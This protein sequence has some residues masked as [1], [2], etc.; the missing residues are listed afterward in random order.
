MKQY[1]TYVGL[2]THKKE[3]TV[4]ILYPGED[5]VQ[6]LSV[7]NSPRELQRFVKR[8]KKQAPGEIRMC[9]EAGPCGFE[10]KRQLE[11]EGVTCEVIA[12]SL[13]PFKPG[14]RVKTDRRDARKLAEYYQKGLLTPVHPPTREEEAVRDLCRC[15]EAAKDAQTR[16]RHQLI[17]FLLRHGRSYTEGSYWTHKH[18][19]WLRKQKFAEAVAQ[20]TY[21]DY[22][23]EVERCSERVKTLEQELDRIAQQ[24]PYRTPVGWLRCFRG[25]DTVTAITIVSELYGFQR[26]T[27]PRQL[28]AFLGLTPS[29]DSTGER[30]KQGAI[31]KAGNQHVRRLLIEASWH[32][33]HPVRVGRGLKKRR[34]GQPKWVIQIADKA[35]R[36]LH[37]RYA[38]L[39]RQGKKETVAIAAVAREMVGFLWSILYSRVEVVE[40]PTG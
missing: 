10:L 11:S 8:V 6:E 31:T 30:R 23:G 29:E 39:R 17:K 35:M 15:R 37:K 19:A 4:C 20:F 36:R 24:E 13:I 33:R 26:F 25:I 1:S 7:K 22:V 34:E 18:W 32:Q 5:T 40:E 16:S 2:D 21:E 14:E 28:M 12:P 27:A 3:H 38:W 9:Y